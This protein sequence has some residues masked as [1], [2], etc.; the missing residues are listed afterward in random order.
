MRFEFRVTGL[1]SYWFLKPDGTKLAVIRGYKPA[2]YMMEA[3]EYIKD[4]KYDTTRIE[5]HDQ[6]EKTKN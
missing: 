6:K 4:Y 5:T 3:F 1:P 2:Q